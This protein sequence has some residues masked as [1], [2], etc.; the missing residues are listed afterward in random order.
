[1][2]GGG[3]KPATVAP[4]VAASTDTA[5]AK[6]PKLVRA[7]DPNKDS[8]EEGGSMW[9]L[10]NPMAW[11]KAM[12]D[13]E[14]A[15]IKGVPHLLSGLT[16]WGGG[17]SLY[18][19]PE[20]VK[21]PRA[22]KEQLTSLKRTV[23]GETI[24]EGY[25]EVKAGRP[26]VMPFVET[27]GNVA[28]VTGVAGG[29]AGAAS[30]GLSAE[31]AAAARG[32]TFV[33]GTQAGSTV[34]A[35]E[36]AAAA[37]ARGAAAGNLAKAAK[38]LKQTERIS[39]KAGAFPALFH[40][41]V[42]DGILFG[43]GKAGRGWANKLRNDGIKLLEANPE[44]VLGKRKI[45][46]ADKYNRWAG[47]PL[48]TDGTLRYGRAKVEVLNQKV[49]DT[50]TKR[51][52]RAADAAEASVNRAMAAIV[53]NPYLVEEFGP[54]TPVEQQAVIATLNGRGRLL[55]RL[56]PLLNLSPEAINHLGRLN[57]NEKFTLSPEG[58][59]L[60][61][62]F[63]NNNLPKAQQQRLSIAAEQL[64][65]EIEKQ[66]AQA[67][68]G[69]GRSKALDAS[70]DMPFP[71]V[72]KFMASLKA[73]GAVDLYQEML[74]LQEQGFFDDL[75]RPEVA[76]Y[77][78]SVV[79]R[80]PRDIALDPMLYPAKERY[81]LAFYNRLTQGLE[82]SA[83]MT[84]GGSPIPPGTS[85]GRPGPSL[86]GTGLPEESIYDQVKDVGSLSRTPRR[87]LVNSIKIL[88]NLKGRVRFLG[89]RLVEL[90]MKTG[91]LER[92]IIRKRLEYETLTG[93][94]EDAQGNR[95]LLEPGE[96][97]GP[98]VVR[99]QGQLE[100]LR[101]HRDAMQ[102]V[103]DDMVAKQQQTVVVDGKTV[104]ADD[105]AA[106]VQ[107]A[108]SLVA[109]AE[110]MANQIV[111]DAGQIGD[112]I[113]Q[114][115]DAKADAAN[116]L[117]EAG[118]DPQPLVE[119]AIEDAMNMPE[120][121]S[122]T[123]PGDQRATLEA[124][125]EAARINEQS[126]AD[127]YNVAR[128]ELLD[129]KTAM[130]EATAAEKASRAPQATT[131]PI[132]GYGPDALLADLQDAI[133]SGKSSTA[134]VNRVKKKFDTEY[135]PPKNDAAVTKNMDKV[136]SSSDKMGLRDKVR[137][138][139]FVINRGGVLWF[140]NSYILTKLDPES[141]L[142]KKLSEKG[143]VKSGKY[144]SVA[145]T[146]S[147]VPKADIEFKDVAP[148]IEP[149]I[150]PTEKGTKST[151]PST[152]VGVY[153]LRADGPVVIFEDPSGARFG[154]NK[155]WVDAILKN[156][157]TLHFWQE[158]KPV[159]VRDVNGELVG[160]A[161]P[162][163]APEAGWAIPT[164]AELIENAVKDIKDSALRDAIR[165]KIE[166]VP[167]EPKL[168]APA[169]AA[170]PA[171]AVEYPEFKRPL[172]P[173]QIEA[174][175][176][177]IAKTVAP[178]KG[179]EK[180]AAA[181][182]A[183]EAVP[184]IIAKI[185]EAL[186]AA[187]KHG[188]ENYASSRSANFDTSDMAF[189]QEMLGNRR[190]EVAAGLDEI[191]GL[192]SEVLVKKTEYS[193]NRD[194]IKT[195]STSPKMRAL[196]TEIRS[197]E[198][199]IERK[200]YELYSNAEVSQGNIAG[201]ADA[202]AGMADNAPVTQAVEPQLVAPSPNVREVY[203]AAEQR[204]I[205]AQDAAAQVE[206]DYRQAQGIAYDAEQQLRALDEGPTDPVAINA[207]D[208]AE[209]QVTDPIIN[210]ADK[211]AWT[212]H[213]NDNWS[214]D[215]GTR[216]YTAQRVVEGL[217]KDGKPK[218]RWTSRRIASDGLPIESTSMDFNNFKELRD[219]V[220]ETTKVDAQVLLETPTYRPGRELGEAQGLLTP[221]ELLLAQKRLSSAE[222][223]AVS[224]TRNIEKGEGRLLKMR[225][226]EAVKRA[227]LVEKTQAAVGLEA[228]L[229]REIYTQP[230]VT[231][232][233]GKPTGRMFVAPEQ[234]AP[235]VV[236]SVGVDDV[237]TG[238]T[239]PG[240]AQLRPMAQYTRTVDEM[241]VDALTDDVALV[242]RS[243]AEA[244]LRRAEMLTQDIPLD[245]AMSTPRDLGQ[246][247]SGSQYVMGGQEPVRSVAPA[248]MQ[249]RGLTGNVAVT[250]EKL[251]GANEGI[252]DII[253]LGRRMA[254]EQR[255]LTLN[256]GF[257][258]VMNSKF[259]VTPLFL[260]GEKKVAELRERA[261]NMAI[262]N[263]FT[264]D[265]VP[266]GVG[267]YAE[268]VLNRDANVRQ[269]FNNAFGD[270]M[271]KEMAKLGW[272]TLPDK[273]I[274]SE[275]VYVDT[276]TPETKYL[277]K[278]AVDRIS[279]RWIPYNAA[280]GRRVIDGYL[281]AN[282]RVTRAFKNL[283]LPLS[284][285]W[286]IGDFISNMMIAN[287]FGVNPA[288]MSRGLKVAIEQNF[289][290]F[291]GAYKYVARNEMPVL[292]PTAELLAPYVQDIGL[293]MDESL[294]SR[295]LDQPEV[296]PMLANTPILKYPFNLARAIKG[297]SYRFNE[298][299][300]RLQRHAFMLEKLAQNLDGLGWTVD[301]I[302][303]HGLAGT[304]SNIQQAFY[305]AADTANDVLGDFMDLSRN[306]RQ[307]ML[308]HMPFYS[309]IKH[310]H[311][312]FF[313]V[314][315]EHPSALMWHAY[316]GSFVYDPEADPY[317]LTTGMWGVP[318]GFGSGNLMTPFADV[319][320][321]PL[322]KGLNK[323]DWSG[324]GAAFNPLVRTGVAAFTGFNIGQGRNI[325]RPAGTAQLSQSGYQQ[326]TPLIGR[327]S[328]LAGFAAQ[329]FPL[330]TKIADIMPDGQLPGTTMQLGPV[331]RY[332]TGQA[333][334]GPLGLGEQEKYGGRLLAI[335]RLFT[336][337]GLPT[338]S[339]E[340]LRKKTLDAQ[341]Q[342][343]RASVSKEK[344]KLKSGQ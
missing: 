272:E 208:N 238:G 70:H 121:I 259:A 181:K 332:D 109:Q 231:T 202:A 285:S 276:I 294:R 57:Y 163:K 107:N 237:P 307:I 19:V 75:S 141:F 98:G 152:V 93:W 46:Q 33:S 76:D 314:A 82:S 182:A 2:L 220:A 222:G 137:G 187:F 59:K 16:G 323:N 194:V 11:N 102:A 131:T 41:K 122:E 248:G 127:E 225:E 69:F 306:E 193:Y 297:G 249:T 132:G 184:A 145:S 216:K 118:V 38:V 206:A 211:A 217:R 229:G 42:A 171:A 230:D 7:S 174:E 228:R 244:N 115:E 254:K 123:S 299:I 94:Y 165:K 253:E 95:V 219:Y 22:V 291:R 34:S 130:E 185:Q 199:S 266:G 262:G 147:D 144:N 271:D 87:F 183:Q 212:D 58:S 64:S 8:G 6:L 15:F 246:E 265:G 204:Y 195:A 85:P 252:Y 112:I 192:L 201:V 40:I 236:R 120:D 316:I 218:V 326:N 135:V 125:L 1:M 226:E 9:N 224:L 197:I 257:K 158:G 311:K 139:L 329:Q 305:D 73:K 313:K 24:R 96:T 78:R 173:K 309:W 188:Y 342:N 170:G 209:A 301:D 289:G 14:M 25:R 30:R 232:V 101:E 35:A 117:D 196:S 48:V 37:G 241:A 298:T 215:T 151:S 52:T 335:P 189:V 44:D 100:L 92:D 89:E 47:K 66:S 281:S 278:Y 126:L 99:R 344:A 133:P 136:L 63:Q 143:E 150:K 333:R 142:Y 177:S 129:A 308:A 146:A 341:M 300:N 282:N 97:P 264:P 164:A 176:A 104:S 221:P 124:Q 148:D 168:V 280:T 318:G 270:L 274:I 339:P 55:A 53:D 74:T 49:L 243:L 334:P 263:P 83:Q 295:G 108:D 134:E 223:R 234:G 245:V 242:D 260:L 153:T 288:A 138:G 319:W 103:Y 128:I 304:P 161:M 179:G 214:I 203:E 21:A 17:V 180:K 190:A 86:P 172:A 302:V 113:E 90:E 43:A 71:V 116:A 159:A 250:S 292:G 140:T 324:V 275:R 110:G 77:M 12:T 205:D 160:L 28:L 321:G 284:V 268:G 255:Q 269:Q 198:I 340:D 256:E 154:I 29:V 331:K 68:K 240:R 336:V 10:L 61:V 338:M 175:T 328:E 18:G 322:Y 36:A 267:A 5:A 79:N 149:L 290:G 200:L 343:L 191:A 56:A 26:P 251:R 325:T 277:P 155:E 32:A 72:E 258:F 337:P 67:R 310:V 162:S 287:I 50:Y 80:A 106:A 207:I 51:Y 293:R 13:V 62:D 327:P 3:T 169:K 91:K 239:G 312:L 317:G 88:N 111:E 81:N 166:S 84:A 315:R 60:A 261:Y 213:G 27:A 279:S 105:V 210:V 186:D 235:S 65:A 227:E 45:E 233:D 20:P 330:L 156:G 320:S 286:Q 167:A 4:V 303:D 283:T 247:Y 296:T 119:A 54:L 23:T 273:G 31:A 39:G 178:L 157:D 114:V